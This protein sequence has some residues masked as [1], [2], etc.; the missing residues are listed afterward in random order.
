MNEDKILTK[1]VGPIILIID[2]DA[3]AKK[4]NYFNDEAYG[5]VLKDGEKDRLLKVCNQYNIKVDLD[6]INDGKEHYLWIISDYGVGLTFTQCMFYLS[7]QNKIFHGLNELEA[8]LSKKAA[9]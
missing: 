5:L 2:E 6:V 1:Q 7:K 9:E 3:I 4:T 8:F